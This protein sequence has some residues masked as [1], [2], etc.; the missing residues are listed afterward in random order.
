[1]DRSDVSSVVDTRDIVDLF[2][3]HFT[4]Q[5]S[6]E[7]LALQ[8]ELRLDFAKPEL[9]GLCSFGPDSELHG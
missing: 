7:Y 2:L 8:A 5:K 3:R 4:G 9:S 1:M 6:L